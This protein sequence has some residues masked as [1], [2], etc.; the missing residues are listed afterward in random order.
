M[1]S[2]VYPQSTSLIMYPYILKATDDFVDVRR[3]ILVQLLVVPEDD[4][5]DVDGAEDGELMRL[6][7]QTP[8][9]LEKG[10]AAVAIVADCPRI[11]HVSIFG[12]MDS[13]VM[14]WDGLGW[15]GMHVLGLMAIFRRPMSLLRGDDGGQF[16]E[17]SLLPRTRISTLFFYPP[18]W[19]ASRTTPTRPRLRIL[20]TAKRPTC[21]KC[22]RR[23][24]ELAWIGVWTG[25]EWNGSVVF[26]QDPAVT[27]DCEWKGPMA[28]FSRKEVLNDRWK[29]DSTGGLRVLR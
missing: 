4:D 28:I 8:F 7:E 24:P 3:R 5:G 22:S 2:M 13:T 1:V 12:R 15:D 20:L 10:D 27:M 6:F 18:T 21:E 17:I 26:L 11:S 16:L 25:M 9:A 19:I 14:G 23:A 29:A